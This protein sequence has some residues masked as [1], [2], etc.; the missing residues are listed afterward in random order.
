VLPLRQ[1]QWPARPPYGAFGVSLKP[2]RLYRHLVEGVTM[3]TFVGK[4]Y[5][6]LTGSTKVVG[7]RLQWR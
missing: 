4:E 5:T 2:P 3:T 1:P 6:S 7:T